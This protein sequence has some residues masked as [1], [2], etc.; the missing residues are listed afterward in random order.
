MCLDYYPLIETGEHF[1]INDP[2]LAS[3][4][5]PKVCNDAVFFQGLL[6]GIAKIEHIGYKLLEQL[7]APYPT[8]VQTAGGGAINKAWQEIRQQKL[9]VSVKQSKYS[10]AA[11]GAATLAAKNYIKR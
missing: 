10:A 5:S 9:G 8:S 4:I 3:R 6:E 11:Y 7:G 2:N 1:P